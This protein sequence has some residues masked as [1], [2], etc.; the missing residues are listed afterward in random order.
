MCS[1]IFFN[2]FFFSFTR[3]IR[4]IK[5]CVY[6]KIF[7]MVD[8]V[9]EQCACFYTTF[10]LPRRR[11]STIFIRFSPWREKFSRESFFYDWTL[12]CVLHV[13]WKQL[14]GLSSVKLRLSPTIFH[15]YFSIFFLFF[16]FLSSIT[17]IV[18]LKKKNLSKIYFLQFVISLC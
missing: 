2:E 4:I 7:A 9:I 16:F 10:P 17:K 12:L 14:G 8:S 13:L 3:Y 18:F 15:F 11:T 5:F 6:C 1:F